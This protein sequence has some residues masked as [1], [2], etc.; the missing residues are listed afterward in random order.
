MAYKGT[1]EGQ[2]VDESVGAIK[3]G[4]TTGQVLRKRSDVDYDTAKEWLAGL[5]E[6]ELKLPPIKR[7]YEAVKEKFNL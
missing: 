3:S 1:Y 6:K 7:R 2:R 4:G 5:T